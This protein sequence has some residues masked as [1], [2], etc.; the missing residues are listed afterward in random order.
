MKSKVISLASF[1]KLGYLLLDIDPEC[2]NHLGKQRNSNEFGILFPGR[3]R[4]FSIANTVRLMSL[5]HL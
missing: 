3:I 4:T 2:F 1:R 5:A